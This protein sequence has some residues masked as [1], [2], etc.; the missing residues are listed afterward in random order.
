MPTAAVTELPEN[1]AE[2]EPEPSLL[3]TVW[4]PLS[5]LTESAPP[6]PSPEATTLLFSNDVSPLNHMWPLLFI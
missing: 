2:V 4:P 1:I 6:L 3:I 5:F